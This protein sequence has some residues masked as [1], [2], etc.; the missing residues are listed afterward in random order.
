M[1]ARVSAPSCQSFPKKRLTA[2]HPIPHCPWFAGDHWDAEPSDVDIGG[3]ASDTEGEEHGELEEYPGLWLGSSF[4]PLLLDVVVEISAAG[5]VVA[6]LLGQHPLRH[7]TKI[8]MGEVV[9]CFAG[10]GVSTIAQ[11]LGLGLL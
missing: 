2:E 9:V 10:C 6:R 11:W 7:P 1:T 4:A 8:E 3:K 5:L